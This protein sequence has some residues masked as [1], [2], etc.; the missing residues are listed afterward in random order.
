MGNANFLKCVILGCLFILAGCAGNKA[1]E[2]SAEV[3]A[4]SSVSPA[5][6]GIEEPAGEKHFFWKVSDENSSVWVLGSVHF[7]DSTFY[8]LD[9][10]IET[11]FV[12]SEELAVEINLNDDSTS[13]EVSSKMMQDGLL[14]AGVTL[15]SVLPRN[16]WNS[17]DSLCAAWNFPVM[18]LQRLR[19]WFAASTLSAVAI[20]RAGI[21]AEYGIDVVLMDRAATDGKAIVGLETAE[22]QVSAL[23]GTGKDSDESQSDSAGVY[24]LK[25]TLR[26]I[27]GLDSMVAQMMRAWKTGNDSLLRVVMNAEFCDEKSGNCEGDSESEK[28]MKADLEERIY[29]SRNAKM[30]GSIAQFLEEDRNVFVVIGA[31]HL[32]LDEDNVIE[33]LRRKGFR[34]RRF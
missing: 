30:A 22:D 1:P 19:P 23:S 6:K 9:S 12:A 27:A 25:T 26:E 17:L 11:A 24:Y 8:P 15:N 14:P 4:E 5:L 29:T 28:K 21:Q 10:V 7:A 31:A 2:V 20:Q 32:A 13:N 34:I 18:A 16:V 3:P 33:L